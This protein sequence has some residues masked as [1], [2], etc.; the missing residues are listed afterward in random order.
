MFPGS[1]RKHDLLQ[2]VKK[3]AAWRE[4]E[5]RARKLPTCQG[6]APRAVS[7]EFCTGK[8]E[9]AA[10]E[11]LLKYPDSKRQNPKLKWIRVVNKPIP[12]HSYA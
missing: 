3:C 4:L 5:Q 6:A 8:G 11:S 9:L 10:A 2:G 1:E 12:E 7:P